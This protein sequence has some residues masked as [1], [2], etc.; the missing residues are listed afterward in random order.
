MSADTQDSN[1]DE[2]HCF[3]R[4]WSDGIHCTGYPSFPIVGEPYKLLAKVHCVR[5]EARA[6]GFQYKLLTSCNDTN[7][8]P[9]TGKDLWWGYTSDLAVYEKPHQHPCPGSKHGQKPK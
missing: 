8:K 2:D 9:K 6:E 4:Q 1:P 7:F 3:R 5:N